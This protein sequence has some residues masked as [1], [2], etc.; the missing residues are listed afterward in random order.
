MTTKINSKNK[1]FFS[2]FLSFKKYSLN[3]FTK[4]ISIEFNTKTVIGYKTE[5]RFFFIKM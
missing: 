4:I 5:N 3:N 1:T 2:L